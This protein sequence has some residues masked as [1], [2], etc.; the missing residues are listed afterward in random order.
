M[1]SRWK[2][3]FA[4]VRKSKK[5]AASDAG[6][7]SAI[8]TPPMPARRF[9]AL[10]LNHSLNSA[11][12]WV[13]RRHF[14]VA[15]RPTSPFENNKTNFSGILAVFAASRRTPVRET[16]STRHR[17]VANEPVSR[18]H[19]SMLTEWRGARLNNFPRD[20]KVGASLFPYT[21]EPRAVKLPN[22]KS[23]RPPFGVVVNSRERK[24]SSATSPPL[25]RWRS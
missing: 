15:L 18:I 8:R 24:T 10:R 20:S 16:S 17:C 19:A 22:R 25:T 23:A 7:A 5:C 3:K 6:H 21:G 1:S 4:R 11:P 12:I 2:S 13:P 9:P 14:T